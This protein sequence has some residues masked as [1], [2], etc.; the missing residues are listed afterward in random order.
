LY[1]ASA[2]LL[3]LSA[4]GVSDIQLRDFAVS[5]SIRTIYQTLGSALQAAIVGSFGA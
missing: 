5:T 4:C 3:W 1:A 2:G